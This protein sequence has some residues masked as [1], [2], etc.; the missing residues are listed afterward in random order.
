MKISLEILPVTNYRKWDHNYCIFHSTYG[1]KVGDDSIIKT[2]Q[3]MRNYLWDLINQY[4]LESIDDLKVYQQEL[5]NRRTSRL[6]RDSFKLISNIY[7]NLFHP[8]IGE[9]TEF[10]YYLEGVEVQ[11]TG[12]LSDKCLLGDYPTKPP[13]VKDKTLNI[14]YHNHTREM[15]ETFEKMLVWMKDNKKPIIIHPL[16]VEKE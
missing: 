8:S 2:N 7:F 4:P 14:Y 12:V 9:I 1:V 10:K 5:D 15:A 11:R 6:E 13:T 16:L 3:E